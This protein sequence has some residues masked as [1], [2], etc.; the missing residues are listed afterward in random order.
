MDEFF[1][2]VIVGTGAA[3]LY[4][5]LNL[6]ERL[7][8]LIL[9]KR[10]ADE[11]DSFLAQGGICMLRGEEDF[12]PYMEDTLRA[13]HYENDRDAVDLMIRSSNS[14]IR[15][16]VRRGV[17]FARHGDGSLDFT[18]EGAHCRPRILYHEDVTGRE[19]TQT[20]LEEAMKRENLILREETTMLDIISDDT[21]CGGVVAAGPDGVPYTVGAGAVV[22]ACG[23]IGGLFKNSTNFPHITGDALAIAMRRN[24]AVQHLDYIQIHPTTLYSTRPGRR[25]LISESA[26]GEGA[27]LYDKNGQRFTDELQ[28]RDLLSAAIREQMEKDGT[29]FVWEDLRPLGE[30]TLRTHFPNICQHCQ[31]EGYDVLRGPIPVVPAQHYFMGGIR[32]DL[33]SR[34]AMPG[35]YACGEISCN[36]VHGRNRLASNSLLESLVFA[37]RAADDILFGESPAFAGNAPDLAPY[38]EQEPLLAAYR[39]EVLNAIERMKKS[40]E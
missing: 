1:D 19:I 40:H 36:G 21:A 31:E 16:L 18:R 33:S 7:T 11:S 2:V 15:D 32:V 28:P 5:A 9:T 37:Q 27:L 6:P 25:F 12:H 8:V 38:R 4:C 20:L 10:K 13:G 22:L 14:I 3:G 17:R 26:R 30:R 39:K 35:L 34:T 24:I 23:G 29:D